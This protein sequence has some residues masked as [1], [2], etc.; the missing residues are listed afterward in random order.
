MV[1][2]NRTVEDSDVEYSNRIVRNPQ[3]IA[4]LG[5]VLLKQE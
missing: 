4:A 5:Y 3:K 2:S 1:D